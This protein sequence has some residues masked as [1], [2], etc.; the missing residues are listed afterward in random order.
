MSPAVVVPL[1]AVLFFFFKHRAYYS[2]DGFVLPRKQSRKQV[3][4]L[5]ATCDIPR[6]A[7]WS[8]TPLQKTYKGHRPI[9][10]HNVRLPHIRRRSA[11]IAVHSAHGHVSAVSIFLVRS[12]VLLHTIQSG[13]RHLVC[14]SCNR[15]KESIHLF[16]FF[17]HTETLF[18]ILTST[19][20][21]KRT[22]FRF[23]ASY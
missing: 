22:K 23:S 20:K 13:V 10:D 2:S 4:H 11:T 8:C 21:P 7:N 1:C 5:D 17:F 14:G 12:D 19:T 6:L 16:F 3:R 18:F 15:I 9:A